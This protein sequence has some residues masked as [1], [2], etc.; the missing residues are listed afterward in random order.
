MRAGIRDSEFGIRKSGHCSEAL[1]FKG[2]VWVGMVLFETSLQS[3]I[4]NP[5]DEAAH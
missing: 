2:R 4:P 3:R 1:P 5:G